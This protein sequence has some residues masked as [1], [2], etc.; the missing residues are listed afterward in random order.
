[1][2]KRKAM[3]IARGLGGEESELIRCIRNVFL[4]N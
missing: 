1:M 2:T 3:K 4:V